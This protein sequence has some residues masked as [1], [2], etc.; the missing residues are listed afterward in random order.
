[1]VPDAS[2]AKGAH[3]CT[4]GA[5]QV[6]A[7]SQVRAVVSLPIVQTL[8]AQTVP[9]GSAAQVPTSPARAQLVHAPAQALAQQTPS[10]QK[11]DTHSWSPAQAVAIGF[12]GMHSSSPAQYEPT[13]QIRSPSGQPALQWVPKASHPK[14]Q[15]TAVGVTQFPVPSHVARGT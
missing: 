4:P 15:L 10:T 11:P 3:D 12:L 9:A 7:P 13:G 2:Q 14:A 6:P 8:A 1:M 5:W